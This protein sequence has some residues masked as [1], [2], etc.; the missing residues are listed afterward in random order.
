[1][2]LELFELLG[3]DD[4]RFSPYC[5]RTRMALAHK[6]LEPETIP[7]RFTDKDKFAFSGSKTV[8][9]IRDGETV[10]SDSWAIACHLEDTYPD[11]PS[12]FGGAVGKAEA[13]FI[14]QW[15]DTTLHI[16]L[17]RLVVKD[18]YDHLDPADH[19]YFRDSRE[20]RLGATL[21]EVHALRDERRPAFVHALAPLRAVLREQPFIC[22]DEPAYGD[23]TV[24]GAFQWAR[25]IS[26][27]RLVEEDNIVFD[28]RRR[29]LDLFDG[30]GRSVLGYPE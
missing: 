22:G 27:Y 9:V 10:V 29:M 13:R 14:G 6:G 19:L 25:C 30:L 15:T 4:R 11:R 24:F 28:W 8:P 2:A 3:I 26:D 5:W 17:I 7:C 16:A 21:E 20:K 12:L 18:I 1:M 23:Y